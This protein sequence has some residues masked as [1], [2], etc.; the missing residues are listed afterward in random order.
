MENLERV[1]AGFYRLLE[2]IMVITMIV[3]FVLVFINVMLR[4]IFNTG[5]DF[6][7]E[8]PRFAFIWMTFI[9]AIIGMHKH[10]RLGVDMLVAALPVLGRKICWGI[11]QVIMT[12]CSIYML[13]GTWLQHEIIAS[14]ASAVMQMSMLWVYGVSYLTGTAITIICLSNL[15]RLF[16]GQVDESEL[17]DV[18]EE[19]MEDAHEAQK[20]IKEQMHREG[21]QP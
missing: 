6:A 12:V 19:G 14:N 3:M 11:S 5:I 20:E 16:L 17:V 9:G 10:T 18:Q 4:M 15:V 8:L 2:I 1:K 21:R 13:Y 7:E